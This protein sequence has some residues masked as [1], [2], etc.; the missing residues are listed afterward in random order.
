MAMIDRLIHITIAICLLLMIYTQHTFVKSSWC[1][2]EIDK[3][4][5]T[6]E[7]IAEELNVR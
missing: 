6:L 4:L 7:D 2:Y 3:M 1:E 5:F